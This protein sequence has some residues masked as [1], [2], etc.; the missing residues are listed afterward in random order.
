MKTYII[1]ERKT[2]NIVH[3]HVQAEEIPTS[4]EDLLK[5][6]EPN[7]D[8]RALDV[9]VVADISSRKFYRVNVKTGQ[10]EESDAKGAVGLAMASATQALLPATAIG[11]K[12]IYINVN[13]ESHIKKR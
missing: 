12:T 13:S 5:L 1:F 10:L 7:Y 2:G 6:I 4:R 9:L 8:V 11:V 3:T